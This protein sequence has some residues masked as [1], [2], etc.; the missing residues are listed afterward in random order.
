MMRARRCDNKRRAPMS[1]GEVCVANIT[2]VGRRRRLVGGLVTLSAACAAAL[3]TGMRGWWGLL[4]I[5]LLVHGW[6]GV[7]QAA[8][9]T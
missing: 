2:P 1:E 7:F 8:D 3:T 9:R 4:T 6:L 5:S